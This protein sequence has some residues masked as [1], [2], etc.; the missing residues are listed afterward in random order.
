MKDHTDIL[1]LDEIFGDEGAKTKNGAFTLK[2][3]GNNLVDLFSRG[4]AFRSKSDAEIIGLFASAFEEDKL[5]A[6]KTLCYLRDIRGGQGERR[7]FRVCLTWLAN[8]FG[9]IVIKNIHNFVEY[10]RWDDIFS[11]VE[12]NIQKDIIEVVKNQIEKD[13]KAK[14]NNISLAAKWMPSIN[15]SSNN[16]VRLAG[17][18]RKNFGWTHKQ[19][20]KNLSKLRAKIN[21]LE[22]QLC[23]NNWDKIDYSKIPS[24]AGLIYAKAFHRHDESR[25]SAWQ[26]KATKGEVKVN[27]STLNPFDIV[28]RIMTGGMVDIGDRKY[29]QVK[30]MDDKSKNDL[31]LF[32]KKLPD[33]FD[34]AGVKHRNILPIVDTSGSMRG[35]PIAAAIGLGI[36]TAERNEGVFQNCFVTFSNEPEVQTLIGDNIYDKINNL[37]KV[38]WNS[39]TNLQKVFEL[40]LRKAI[41]NKVSPSG[42]P[43]EIVLISDME[44]DKVSPDARELNLNAIEDQ[45]KKAG[46]DLPHFTFWNVKASNQSPAKFDAKGIRM[47]SGYSPSIFISLFKEGIETP[48]DLLLKVINGERYSGIIL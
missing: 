35:N 9:D 24:R 17:V 42:M 8:N 3:S 30:P 14:N 12:T 23:K 6:I 47:I 33:Y 28:T 25:Y 2:T 41:E 4:G 26:S 34:S 21:V 13:L 48:L 19:Y 39:N 29:C 20:R 45:Y 1:D 44:F 46:Y 37:S 15:T 40:I 7:F 32:W 36:Y 27:T 22:T 31:D 38:F 16:T 5:L 10:G 18:F 11:L 43:Q